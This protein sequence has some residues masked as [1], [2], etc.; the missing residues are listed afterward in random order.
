MLDL[1]TATA[2]DFEPAVGSVFEVLLGEAPRLE[3]VLDEVSPLPK[4]ADGRQ[5]FALSFSG[6]ARPVLAQ[7]T[8]R[9]SHPELGEFEL[10]LGPVWMPGALEDDPITYEAVFS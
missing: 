1:S 3:L 6:P 7:V 2:S 8:H 4:R 10:F 5:P 9:V